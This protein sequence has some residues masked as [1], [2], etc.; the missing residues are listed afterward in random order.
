MSN[1]SRFTPANSQRLRN[2][3]EGVYD[4]QPGVAATPGLRLDPRYL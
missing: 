2:N 1:S 4:F 3:A